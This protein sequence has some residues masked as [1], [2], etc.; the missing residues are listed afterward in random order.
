MDGFLPAYG[1]K[2]AWTV[3]ENGVDKEYAV[4]SKYEIAATAVHPS[5]L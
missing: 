3:T 2:A 5:R 1:V 4:Y